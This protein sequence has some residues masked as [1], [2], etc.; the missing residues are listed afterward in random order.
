MCVRMGESG[1]ESEDQRAGEGQRER[2]ERT[3]EPTPQGS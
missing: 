2:D 3:P 1:F